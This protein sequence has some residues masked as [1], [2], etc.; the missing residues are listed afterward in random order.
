MP[1]NQSTGFILKPTE[2]ANAW[3]LL[4]TSYKVDWVIHRTLDFE[5]AE[6]IP[7][8]TVLSFWCIKGIAIPLSSHA[9][10]FRF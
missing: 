9:E 2:Y 5:M 3:D 4:M 8:T 6:K 10:E 7:V 1:S